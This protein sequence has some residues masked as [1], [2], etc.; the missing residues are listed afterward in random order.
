MD[1]II[2][3]NYEK[4]ASRSLKRDKNKFEEIIGT[5]KFITNKKQ[6]K[7]PDITAT[8]RQS[9]TILKAAEKGILMR[10]TFRDSLAST[11]KKTMIENNV[12][13]KNQR[14]SKNLLK[15]MQKNIQST[16]SNYTKKN[17]ELGMPSNIYAIAVTETRSVVDSIRYQY[18]GKLNKEI[19]GA[20]II[21]EWYH[22]DSIPNDPRLG[23]KKIS[24]QKRELNQKFSVPVYKKIGG[25]WKFFGRVSADHPHDP[26][27]PASEIISCS[28]EAK[29]R[30]VKTK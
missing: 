3:E 12:I 21:K 16:F 13:N 8:V 26:A 27:L 30:V 5:A 1:K 7:L 14:I 22:N 10:K 19:Q 6:I 9:P 2:S 24:G 20:K 15:K 18:A 11:I 28:C 17:P 25:S 23:H 29:Y 4:I